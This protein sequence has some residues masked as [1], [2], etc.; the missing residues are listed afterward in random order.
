MNKKCGTL[1]KSV[2]H[3]LYKIVVHW[4]CT[5]VWYMKI[6]KLVGWIISGNS[7]IRPKSWKGGDKFRKG[8]ENERQIQ[9]RWG[10]WGT[11]SDPKGGILLKVG[12]GLQ[13]LRFQILK[14]F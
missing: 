3:L 6:C 7:G 10:K 5:T 9:E 11:N 14:N 12:V 1:A 8:G 2:V 13:I 4:L